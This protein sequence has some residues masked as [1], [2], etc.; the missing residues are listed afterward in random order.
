M[1]RQRM[2]PALAAAILL[3]LALLLTLQVCAASENH[4]L[5]GYESAPGQLTLHGCALEDAEASQF[6][7]VLS[8]SSIPI[9]AVSNVSEQ[10]I[11]TTVY[12]LV[13]ISGSMKDEQMEQVKEALRSIAEFLTE[14]DHMVIGTLGNDLV[15]SGF[16]SSKEEIE[17]VI[18]SFS[19]E[20]HE[21]TNLYAGI[22][23]SL[24]LLASDTRVDTRHCL[25]ILS[26]GA[27][28]QKTGITQS[29]AE[30]AVRTSGI[31]VYT[32]A[33]LRSTSTSA[34]QESAKILGSFARMSVGGQHF[35]PQLEDISIPEIALIIAESWKN[36]LVLTLDTSDIVPERD[37]LLLSVTYTSGSTSYT[38]NLTV[39]AR[40]L[41]P[42]PEEPEALP[43]PEA[44]TELEPESFPI[45]FVV[46]GF[47][48]LLA[49]LLGIILFIKRQKQKSE[50][51]AAEQGLSAG[52]EAPVSNVSSQN[53][54][55]NEIPNLQKPEE[56]PSSLE[57]TGYEIHL[58]AIGYRDIV[59]TLYLPEGR[60]LTVGRSEK[61]DLVL[62][63]EDRR[64]S[65]IHCSLRCSAG[66]LT[67]KDQGSTNGTFV[68][69]IPIRQMGTTIVQSG[70]TLR[71]GSY[72][73]RVDIQ[74]RNWNT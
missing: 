43:E 53:E 73:Y 32:I 31:P 57:V 45:G 21:D 65:S 47:C 67:V 69:G 59:H 74:E 14:K 17:A 30:A 58:T 54:T 48:G 15:S 1:K 68:N 25:I 13:D 2:V 51:V 39:Y 23:E 50:K 60:E 38:D 63:T 19:S 5:Q 40:D 7:A 52:Q 34:Q 9:V 8:G 55:P 3:A 6:Q 24:A 4:F 37:E 72:E 29:E 46:G 22:V 66:V 42:L 35:T 12:C 36:G 49:I 33:T 20:R 26:D 11:P 61:A 16:L 18:S 41:L 64:L 56:N 10:E 70:H 28:M 71:M 62:D 44:D 27:D